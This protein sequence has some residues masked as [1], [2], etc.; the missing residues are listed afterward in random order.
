MNP[1]YYEQMSVLLDE[2][3][4]LRRQKAIEYQEYLKHIRD[5]SSKIIRLKKAHHIILALWIVVLNERYM[6]ILERMSY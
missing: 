2:L 3:I 6:I 5:L 4:E 1:K